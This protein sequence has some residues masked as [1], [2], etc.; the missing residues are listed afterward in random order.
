MELGDFKSITLKFKFKSRFK[1][2]YP[3]T[4]LDYVKSM[5]SISDLKKKGGR[6]GVELTRFILYQT[7][8][9]YTSNYIYCQLQKSAHMI[10]PLVCTRYLQ[11]RAIYLSK[12]NIDAYNFQF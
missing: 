6:G 3:N 2:K 7:A 10:R 12:R 1:F 4:T 8:C 11:G 5:I 9:I